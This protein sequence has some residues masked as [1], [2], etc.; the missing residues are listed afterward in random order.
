MTLLLALLGIL[1]QGILSSLELKIQEKIENAGVRTILISNHVKPFEVPSTEAEKYL[2]KDLLKDKGKVI[3]FKRLGVSATW[4]ENKRIPIYAYDRDEIAF[5]DLELPFSETGAYYFTKNHDYDEPITLAIIDRERRAVSVDGMK[6]E[7]PS[8]LRSFVNAD[9]FLLLPKQYSTRFEATGYYSF[10]A[11]EVDRLEDLGEVIGKLETLFKF[12]RRNVQM[13]DQ[14]QLF[15]ELE[16]LYSIQSQWRIGVAL[17]ISAVLTL[18]IGSTALLEF[19][20]NQY[21]IALLK[22]FG[23]S[24]Y[25]IAISFIV[26]NLVLVSLGLFLAAAIMVSASQDAMRALSNTF[27]TSTL[28]WTFSFEDLNV[29]M[30]ASYIGV[31]LALLPV[32][33]SLKKPVGRVLQ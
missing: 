24:S 27:G 9:N 23:V 13:V 7:I 33:N 30:M 12:D 4:R 1:I 14:R 28:E 10:Q 11:V 16:K 26:E 17:L 22:S 20:Q 8:G 6:C 21:V 25:I 18:L 5:F 3:E 31:A 15:D 2:I 32:F 29:L 19:R